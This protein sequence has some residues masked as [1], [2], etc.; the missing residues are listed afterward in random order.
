MRSARY[1]PLI[2][3]LRETR[4]SPAW[5]LASLAVVAFLAALY[6]A[7]FRPGQAERD[8][9]DRQAAALDTAAANDLRILETAPRYRLAAEVDPV[10]GRV[11]G[12]AV[13]D[14]TNNTEDSLAELVLRLYPNAATIYGGGAL[15]VTRAVL[16]DSPLEIA[17]STDPTVLRLPLPTPLEP[18]R[19]TT[20][21]LVFNAQI[22]DYPAQGY[23]IFSRSPRVFV[24]AGWYPVLAPYEQGWLTPPVPPVG[25]ALQA[26]ISFYDVELTLPAGYIVASTG[27]AGNGAALTP[28]QGTPQAGTAASGTPTSA[29]TSAPAASPGATQTLRFVS[30]PVREFAFAASREFLVRAVRVGGVTLR[31]FTLPAQAP[32]TPPEVSLDLLAEAYRAYVARYGPYPHAE[33][34]LVEAPITISGYEFSGMVVVDDELRVRGEPASYE[35]LLAHEVAH[36]WWYGLVG[37]STVAEPWLDEAHATYSAILYLEHAGKSEAAAALLANWEADAAQAE[38]ASLP[39]DASAHDFTDWGVYRQAVYSRGALFLHELRKALGQA[40]F[41]ELL[42]RFQEVHRYGRAT[43]SEYLALAEELAGRELDNLFNDYFE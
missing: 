5:V 36:Q 42:R 8:F 34:D 13:I 23:G 35:Y 19:R 4:L 32:A 17:P 12:L 2:S 33:L 6:F 25:D 29:S 24:L 27:S 43:G 26:E 11:N 28:P 18:A 10:A 22:P 7:A 39:V 21:S 15:E 30:G 9:H 16:G 3:R 41:F 31:S 14:Y 1:R 40:K 38:T 20:V 37:T